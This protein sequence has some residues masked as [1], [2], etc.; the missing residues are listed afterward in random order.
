[1]TRIQRE[2]FPDPAAYNRL[3]GSFVLTRA[4][5]EKTDSRALILHPLPRVDEI[6]PDVDA[7]PAA[8]YFRQARGGMYL[9]MALLSLL[10]GGR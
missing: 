1:M 3:S 6:S 9:R 4:L 5:Y 7:L 10:A 8:A 2:R